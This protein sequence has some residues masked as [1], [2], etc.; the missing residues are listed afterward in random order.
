MFFFTQPS[1]QN[2]IS[3]GFSALFWVVNYYAACFMLWWKQETTA[4][5][6]RLIR[7]TTSNCEPVATESAVNTAVVSSLV[8]PTGLLSWLLKGF[9][10]S[11]QTCFRSSLKGNNSQMGFTQHNKTTHMWTRWDNL[12]GR[13][14]QD[15]KY[16]RFLKPLFRSEEA[17]CMKGES[18]RKTPCFL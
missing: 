3:S 14:P 18:S 9:F 17:F 6:I 5:H 16:P 12:R 8:E 11:I 4:N 10:R 1:Y 7:N 13:R 15:V 2:L